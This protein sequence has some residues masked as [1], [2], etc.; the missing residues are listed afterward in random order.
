M[1]T[2]ILVNFNVV[3]W[4]II[5]STLFD[6]TTGIIESEGNASEQNSFVVGM[7]SSNSMDSVQKAML[8]THHLSF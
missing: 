3:E 7:Y 2:I 1:V 6:Y 5:L 8:E 4:F